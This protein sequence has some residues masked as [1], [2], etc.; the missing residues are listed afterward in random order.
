MSPVFYTSH[1]LDSFDFVAPTKSGE[2]SNSDPLVWGL[3]M[4]LPSV[5]QTTMLLT[6]QIGWITTF[7]N[8]HVSNLSNL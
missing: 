7:P 5:L 2:G 1:Y 8:A 3:P 6:P 4:C